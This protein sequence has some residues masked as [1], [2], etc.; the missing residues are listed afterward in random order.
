MKLIKVQEATRAQKRLRLLLDGVPGAGKTTGSLLIANGL[1]SHLPVN[2]RKDK[3]LLFDT[4]AGR[5]SLKSGQFRFMNVIFDEIEEGRPVNSG[6]YIQLIKYAEDNQ[7]EVLILDSVTP[8]WDSVLAEHNKMTG[9]SYANWG[10]VKAKFHDPFINAILKSRVHII[11]TARAKTVNALNEKGQR[12]KV[13]LDIKQQ[14]DFPYFMD[15]ILHIGADNCTQVEKQEN[16]DNGQPLLGIGSF[17]ITEGT[18]KRLAEWLSNAED[19]DVLTLKDKRFKFLTKLN[20]YS[21]K[22][23]KEHEYASLDLEKLSFEQIIEYGTKLVGD[24]NAIPE[25]TPTNNKIP[26]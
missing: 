8:Q 15:F 20:E 18:G 25:P 7:Y 22:A 13:G 5:A 1:L 26:V 19:P 21:V 11:C 10:K 16:D 24:I 23:G 4:E 12:N 9:N 6:D 14:D 17:K 3:I 2:D